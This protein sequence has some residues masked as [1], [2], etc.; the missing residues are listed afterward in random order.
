MHWH[1]HTWRLSQCRPEADLGGCQLTLQLQ[2]ANFDSAAMGT[3]H[4]YLHPNQCFEPHR[5]AYHLATRGGCALVPKINDSMR[6]AD[7]RLT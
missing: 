7:S 2:H 6:S 1:Q 4:W 5:R 3:L